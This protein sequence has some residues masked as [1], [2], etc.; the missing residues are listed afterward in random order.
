MTPVQLPFVLA[1]EEQHTVNNKLFVKPRA[2]NIRYLIE[3]ALEPTYSMQSCDTFTKFKTCFD[4]FVETFDVRL[5]RVDDL[6]KTSYR[7]RNQMITCRLFN[8]KQPKYKYSL[9]M[10]K[11]KL[12]CSFWKQGRTPPNLS[13]FDLNSA[14]VVLF[15][16]NGR[17]T[18]TGGNNRDLLSTRMADTFS[19]IIKLFCKHDTSLAE[20]DF[21]VGEVEVKNRL[22][23][24]TFMFH[25]I[26]LH[27]FA[28]KWKNH[29][30]LCFQPMRIGAIYMHPLPEFSASLRVA[31]FATGG[32]NIM[33]AISSYEIR[34]VAF[35]MCA[36]L[37][38]FL[39]QSD[40][41]IQKWESALQNEKNLKRYIRNTE[42]HTLESKL[43]Q[44][45]AKV[46][47][48]LTEQILFDMA[49]EKL[50]RDRDDPR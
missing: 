11:E 17:V 47:K 29:R 1:E 14:P 25:K 38:P 23:T 9:K 27:G 48:K 44:K 31:I 10:L 42:I 13:I 15:T 39:L 22:A 49:N 8:R 46:V 36:L 40:A 34:Y 16:E 2:N 18:V 4:K 21:Y 12:I 6:F 3:T 20:D 50:K 32:M 33:G 24:N 43:V 7:V 35:L 41:K 28:E 5:G 26:N 30:P 37:R 19:C 45:G